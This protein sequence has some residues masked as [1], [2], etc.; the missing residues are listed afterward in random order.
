MYV[1]KRGTRRDSRTLRGQSSTL[2]ERG[3]TEG[4]PRPDKLARNPS[5]WRIRPSDVACISCGGREPGIRAVMSVDSRPRARVRSSRL[6]T[7]GVYASTAGEAG[8]LVPSSGPTE[9]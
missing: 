7:T 2:P 9:G 6:V 1:I 4:R 3:A 5:P 8:D